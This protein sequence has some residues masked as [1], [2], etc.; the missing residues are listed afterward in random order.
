MLSNT[1]PL[2]SPTREPPASTVRTKLL[3][4]MDNLKAGM[5]KCLQEL[6]EEEIMPLSDYM[7]KISNTVFNQAET[8]QK[9]ECNLDV[10]TQNISKLDTRLSQKEIYTVQQKDINRCIFDIANLDQN[11][12]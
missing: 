5:A 10:A 3:A 2:T 1:R 8:L 6:K 11:N 4:M 12:K 7:M 9:V